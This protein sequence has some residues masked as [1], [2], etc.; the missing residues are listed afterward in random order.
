MAN[1]YGLLDVGSIQFDTGN[2]RIRKSIEKHGRNITAE[3]IYF[4]LRTS[5]DGTSS[6]VPSFERLKEAIRTTKGISSPIIVIKA[7]SGYVCIDGNTR[8]AIYRDF[9]SEGMTGN[10]DKIP[11]I[12]QSNN[13][14]FAKDCIRLQAHL[15]GPRQWPAYEKARYLAQL[16]NTEYMSWQNLVAM[17][18]GSEKAIKNAISG[19]H[20][21]EQHYH[22]RL[23]SDEDF[24]I[25]RF[26]GFLEFHKNPKIEQAVYEA[27][28]KKDD[29][30]DW[31]AIGSDNG[32]RKIER[33]EDVRKLPHVLANQKAKD[34]FIRGGKNSITNA[35][36]ALDVPSA[37]N[38][39]KTETL[40]NA[41]MQDLVLMLSLRLAKMP[42]DEYK[43]LEN[44][45]DPES[46]SLKER[47][48]ELA[49]DI[50]QM[51][52]LEHLE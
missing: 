42:Y 40:E 52:K 14:E 37:D 2:P 11:C 44:D 32:D 13:D 27:G 22:N 18:G 26:S 45:A 31:I 41:S 51:L 25:T 1:Q 35:F 49:T 3:R 23:A 34:I 29:F 43:A 28:F 20:D 50:F 46:V 19:Y 16:R 6:G 39:D 10:W 33:L 9:M 7:I 36:K 47:L 30:A 12:I 15:I 5:E 24:D 48:E 4:A 38:A 17:G 21:M 8:L